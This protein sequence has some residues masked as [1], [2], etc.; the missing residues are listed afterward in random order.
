MNKEEKIKKN[1]INILEN[2]YEK[3]NVMVDFGKR[4]KEKKIVKATN[5]IDIYENIDRKS[6]TG[7]LRPAQL[8]VLN[9]WYENK[10][11]KKI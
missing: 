5:P 7:P 2:K 10:K 8:N 11:M 6:E 1:R 4:L 3:R 9:N